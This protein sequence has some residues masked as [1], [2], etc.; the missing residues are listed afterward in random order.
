MYLFVFVVECSVLWM[1]IC[2]MLRNEEIDFASLSPVASYCVSIGAVTIHGLIALYN[3]KKL[4]K[5]QP[6]FIFTFFL[7]PVEQ[8]ILYYYIDLIYLPAYK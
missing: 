2:F 3:M 5:E 6:D 7:H 8:Q 4:M 1:Y